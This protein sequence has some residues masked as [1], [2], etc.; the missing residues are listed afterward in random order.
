LD[1][2]QLALAE[3]ERKLKEKMARMKKVIEDAPRI[4]AERVQ[5]QREE[6][7]RRAGSV[8][9]RRLHLSALPDP[10]HLYEANVAVPAQHKRM[11]AERRQGRLTF[12]ILLLALAAAIL[13]LYYTVTL[14]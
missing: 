11:R 9:K 14:G 8:E 4:A 5:A 7:V 10:R 3:E 12:F 13:Y 1:T 2:R 6:L